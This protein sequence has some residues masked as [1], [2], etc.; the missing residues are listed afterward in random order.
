MK[1]QNLLGMLAM[2]AMFSFQDFKHPEDFTR[3]KIL[4]IERKIVIP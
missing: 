1:K 2:G 3:N 4:R